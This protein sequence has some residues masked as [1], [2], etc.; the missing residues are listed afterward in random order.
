M[1]DFCAMLENMYCNCNGCI[2]YLLF[3][4]QFLYMTQVVFLSRLFY[5]KLCNLLFWENMVFSCRNLRKL[6]NVKILS[7]II[8]S[9]NTLFLFFVSNQFFKAFCFATFYIFFI[10]H[11]NDGFLLF[12]RFTFFIVMKRHNFFLIGD[13]L[14][15][16]SGM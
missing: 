12:L 8:F 3:V 5:S 9:L 4:L 11:W 7:H 1:V 15:Y 16:P 14:L 2:L 6:Q 13:F 10:V